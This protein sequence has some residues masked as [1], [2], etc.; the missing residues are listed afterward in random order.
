MKK[1]PS[2]HDFMTLGGQ[3]RVIAHRGFSAAAPENTMAAYRKAID[4][5]ADMIEL[6]VLLTKDREV[7]CIHDE[8]VNRTSNGRGLVASLTLE[9][10]RKLDMGS[11]F[12]SEFAGERIPL[13]SEVLDLAKDRIPL[14][15]EIKTEA[16]SDEPKDGIEEK[17][18]K[19][20]ND[21]NMRDQIVI[22]SFDPRALRHIRALDAT[23]MT[24]SLYDE[25]RQGGM[26][27]AHIMN[28]VGSNGFNLSKS[29]VTARIVEECHSLN[30]PVAVYTVDDPAQFDDLV[31]LEVDA[32]F[33]NHPDIMMA[34]VQASPKQT[35]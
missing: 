6:D 17:V 1:H 8:T 28:E 34:R 11:W 25:Q 7:V 31:G 26:S 3:M 4:I 29:Q 2:I 15:I 10:I 16:V 5:G 14:N 35:H 33:S 13:L 27:P 21:Q 9:E 22:S 24:A 20:I 19:L 12:S 18:L 30:R 23:I 32:I